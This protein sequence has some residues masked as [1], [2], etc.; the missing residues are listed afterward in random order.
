M[1]LEN[2]NGVTKEKEKHNK[3]SITLSMTG[4]KQIANIILIHN[5]LAKGTAKSYTNEDCFIQYV[6][7]YR[8]HYQTIDCI[9]RQICKDFTE[10]LNDGTQA[11]EK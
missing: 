8:V 3:L 9:Y 6:I 10:L 2:K 7:I 1:K 5:M 11:C 4:D